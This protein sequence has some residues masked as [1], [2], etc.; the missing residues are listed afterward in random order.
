MNK[1]T[2][3]APQW[4]LDMMQEWA[5]AHGVSRQSAILITSRMGVEATRNLKLDA[6]GCQQLAKALRK[7]KP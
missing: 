6:E 4:W 2:I 5:D 7:E 3:R 1:T